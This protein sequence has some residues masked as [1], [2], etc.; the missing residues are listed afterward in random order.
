M[1][2]PLTPL[3]FLE[4]SERVYRDKEAV[5]CGET[6][7]TYAEYARRV[8][9]LSSVLADRLGVQRGDRVLYL[10]M[11]CHRLLE[12][13][14]AV[15]PLGAI[16][17]PVNIRLS[18]AEISF[19]LHDSEPVALFASPELLPLVRALDEPA[20]LRHH[21][22]VYR[23]A[24]GQL[25]EGWLE[26]DALLE[27]APERPFA[28]PPDEREVVEIFY[29]SG[30]TGRPKGVMLTHRNLYL[31]ALSTMLALHTD[32][33]ER[34][35]VGTVPLFHV[36]AWGTPQYLVAAGGTQ[37]VVPRFDPEIFARTVQ[38]ERVTTALMV[39]TMLNALLNWP[40]HSKYDFSSLKQIVLGGAPVA[41]ELVRRARQELGCLVRVGY[42]L[43]E[44]CPVVSVAVIKATLA[45][46][47]EEELDRRLAMTGLPL[48]G[49]DVR[50]VRE[51]GSEVAWNGQEV[52]EI[53]VRG[54]NVMAGYWRRP[55]E[56]EAAFADGWLR[57]GDLAVVDSEGYLNI[58]DRK[59]DIIISGGENISSIEVEDVLY[60]HPAVLEAAVL[61][62]P[63]P[64]WGEVPVAVVVLK[65][66][67]TADE[68]ELIRFVR[69]R[70]AHFKAPRRVLFAS[71][72]PKTG[73]GKIMKA[74]LRKTYFGRSEAV[75]AAGQG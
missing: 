53:L 21:V 15:L 27:R 29:T 69:D 54:D 3:R 26:Y 10:G 65:P 45:D 23:G 19:I 25:P 73:T 2:V 7:L 60:T 12:L 20:S 24:D 38:R 1:E 61:G 36:N 28:D 63:D 48:L 34:M 72:L 42:G 58:V 59:K 68:E 66:G 9:R 64:Q 4:R 56:T 49:N 39:S 55:E 16:L 11:N 35:I 46:R 44:T 6:R 71:E 14:Y 5:V 37:V 40:D 33:T 22:L 74:E 43:T 50:V 52:G 70:L 13:Y 17:V 18:P 62:A 67:A 57:T 32:D 51:D 75:G 31:H 8:R 41:Y 47:P 30:T